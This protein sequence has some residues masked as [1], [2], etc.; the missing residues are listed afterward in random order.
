[1]LRYTWGVRVMVLLLRLSVWG[2]LVREEGG[3]GE[4]EGGSR[5]GAEGGSVFSEDAFSW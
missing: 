3:W 4:G 2:R 1:M 5:E